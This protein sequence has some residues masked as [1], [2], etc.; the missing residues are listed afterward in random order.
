MFRFGVPTWGMH[1][2]FDGNEEAFRAKY[3][4]GM[5]EGGRYAIH[6][7]GVCLCEFSFSWHGESL[8]ISQDPPVTIF[9]SHILEG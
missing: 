6:G 7:G 9:L 2:K 5:E 4:L 3:G 8:G 1:V